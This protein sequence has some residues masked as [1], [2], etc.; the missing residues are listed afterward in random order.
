MKSTKQQETR[1][2]VLKVLEPLRTESLSMTIEID[3]SLIA[4]VTIETANE[5]KP[6]FSQSLGGIF[7]ADRLMGIFSDIQDYLIEEVFWGEPLPLSPLSSTKVPCNVDFTEDG[8]VLRESG[9]HRLVKVLVPM[10]AISALG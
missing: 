2:A 5:S 9:T 3:S 4:K 1:E 6:F 10:D 7:V 8:I